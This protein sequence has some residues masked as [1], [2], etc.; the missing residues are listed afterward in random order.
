MG[1][2]CDHGSL[3]GRLMVQPPHVFRSLVFPVL[4]W[5]LAWKRLSPG[6]HCHP[7]ASETHPVCSWM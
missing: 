2:T 5:H 3:F 7:V 4:T 6:S 1:V